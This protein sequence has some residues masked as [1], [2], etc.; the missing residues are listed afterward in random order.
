MGLDNAVHLAKVGVGAALPTA[1]LMERG[2][3]ISSVVAPDSI[4]IVCAPTRFQMDFPLYPVG[5]DTD[6]TIRPINNLSYKPAAGWTREEPTASANI[7]NLVQWSNPASPLAYNTQRQLAQATVW[8][9]YQ[10]GFPN[11]APL[12]VPGYGRVR[13]AEQIALETV[14]VASFIQGGTREYLP[15]QVIG[16]YWDRGGTLTNRGPRALYRRNFRIDTERQ[17][18]MFEDPVVFMGGTLASPQYLPANIVL[19]T[20]CTIRDAVTWAFARLESNYV[21]PGNKYGTGPKVI[22]HDDVRLEFKPTALGTGAVSNLAEILPEVSYYGAAAAAEYQLKLPQDYAYAGLVAISPDGAIQQVSWNITENGTTTRAG[23]NTEFSSVVPPYKQRRL[24]EQ[25]YAD[26]FREAKV[27]AEAN[28]RRL[29]G[30]Y[31]PSN[32]RAAE[33]LT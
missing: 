14:Q 13:Y 31:N 27:A 8:R 4:Q 30:R 10:L 9:W 33:T 7:D 16:T 18:V 17:L 28:R 3:T 12:T 20:A 1:N 26:R 29:P 24:T 21:I 22:R 5:L 25:F 6:G 2:D 32:P 15:A 11:S 19:R 23:R